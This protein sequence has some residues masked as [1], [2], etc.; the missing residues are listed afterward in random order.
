MMKEE[1][2]AK[3][4]TPQ[5]RIVFGF[6]RL[7]ENLASVGGKELLCI[8]NLPVLASFTGELLG[9]LD[10]RKNART[11]RDGEFDQVTSFFCF[12]DRVYA[13][14]FCGGHV[15]FAQRNRV[16]HAGRVRPGFRILVNRPKTYGSPRCAV[17][18]GSAY[19]WGFKGRNPKA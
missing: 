17:A 11:A 3:V 19:P 7:A 6:E 10:D 15:C 13:D 1:C 18:A 2:E 8:G 12:E 9:D 14:D 4:A 16:S 5:I